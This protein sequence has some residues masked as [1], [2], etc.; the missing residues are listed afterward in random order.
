[1]RQCLK[2]S[3]LLYRLF[4]EEQTNLYDDSTMDVYENKHKVVLLTYL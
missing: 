2:C 1:M 4:Y 3:I